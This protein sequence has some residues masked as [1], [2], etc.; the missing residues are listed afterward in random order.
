MPCRLSG[1]IDDAAILV[2]M[3]HD[4]DELRDQLADQFDLLYEEAAKHGGR[5]MSVVAAPVGD[6]PALPHRHARKRARP[7][8]APPRRLAGYGSR[9][10]GRLAKAAIE[11][12]D[13]TAND[14]KRK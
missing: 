1:D 9:D 10:P 11:A 14:P 6:R 5:I 7:L 8:H 4:E 12:P 13:M 2:G 3:H